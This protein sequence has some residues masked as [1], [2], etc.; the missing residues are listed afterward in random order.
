MSG[1]T[2][3]AT[4]ETASADTVCEKLIPAVADVVGAPV[5]QAGLGTSPLLRQTPRIAFQRAV[6]AIPVRPDGGPDWDNRLAGYTTDI[7]L[8]GLG[9]EFQRT[10]NLQTLGL[11]VSLSPADGQGPVC[12]GVDVTNTQYVRET[13]H[14]GTHFTG[15]AFDLLKPEN[16]TPR[17][18]ARRWQF[19]LAYAEAILDQ[20]ARIGVLEPVLWDRVQLC[21]RCQAL[22]TFRRGC[23][24]CGSARLA[25]DRLI[26][27][28]ACAH[29]GLA[30]EFDN[31]GQLT[32][33]K[34][35]T[36]SL[37]VG[38]DYEYLTGPFRCQDCH[39]TGTEREQVAQCLRCELRFPAHQSHERELKGYRA[40]R[41][42]PLAFLPSLG[43]TA[44][45]SGGLAP[46]RHAAL[47]AHQDLPVRA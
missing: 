24:A 18:N 8:E 4:R 34:C 11:V 1:S 35:R 13:C 33:P 21:P 31:H 32:C 37:V 15:F 9:L 28:F 10:V 3:V 2:I 25:N 23:N 30:D 43:P 38:A 45:L 29:V 16:L 22:P 7:G 27:H 47:R 5:R 42:D 44:S 40:H 19:E 36:R 46:D 39:W 12:C 20:W 6:L 17:L 26:H 14:L 41:L